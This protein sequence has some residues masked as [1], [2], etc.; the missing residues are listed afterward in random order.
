MANRT[1]TFTV[2]S[3]PQGGSIYID[4]VNTMNTTPHT[5]QYLESELLSPK[6]ITV[7]SANATS[8]ESYIIKSEIVS[9]TGGSTGGGGG[10][11][12]GGGGYGNGDTSSP[13]VHNYL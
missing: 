3:T 1:I 6:T 2:N 12:Y 5:L 11:S 8:N 4:G 10:S 7:R 13:Y 9:P